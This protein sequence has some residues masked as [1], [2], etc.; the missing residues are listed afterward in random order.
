MKILKFEEALFIHEIL[1]ANTNFVK[2][3]Q[4]HIPLLAIHLTWTLSTYFNPLSIWIVQ[5]QTVPIFGQYFLVPCIFQYCY[6]FIAPGP[7]AGLQTYFK[8]V[9]PTIQNS[10]QHKSRDVVGFIQPFAELIEIS[11]QSKRKQ[12]L[13]IINPVYKGWGNKNK[14]VINFELL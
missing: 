3:F 1:I 8:L 12:A 6:S 5:I 2:W 14:A 10:N 7:P 4:W 9:W 13:F 11:D